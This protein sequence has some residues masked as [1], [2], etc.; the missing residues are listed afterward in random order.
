M[1]PND[2]ADNNIDNMAVA[3]GNLDNDSNAAIP[4]Q[5]NNGDARVRLN[6]EARRLIEMM[7]DE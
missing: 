6:P 1:D 3:C 4:D 2:P 7:R 5:V